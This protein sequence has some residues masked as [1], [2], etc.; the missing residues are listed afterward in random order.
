MSN[1]Q[2][3]STTLPTSTIA[4]NVKL[5]AEILRQDPPDQNA[6][7]WQRKFATLASTMRSWIK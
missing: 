1:T 6:P 4:H 5:D 7:W 2:T 3:E